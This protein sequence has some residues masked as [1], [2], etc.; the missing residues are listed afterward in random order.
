MHFE[1]KMNAVL[2]HGEVDRAAGFCL[3]ISCLDLACCCSWVVTRAPVG[4]LKGL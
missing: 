3:S 4:L 1:E 2:H